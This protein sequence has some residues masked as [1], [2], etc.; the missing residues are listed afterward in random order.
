MTTK[1]VIFAVAT[2]LLYGCG[3]SQPPSAGHAECEKQFKRF[4][5]GTVVE[6]PKVP[7][8]GDSREYYFAWN[9]GS[10]SKPII[11]N[12]GATTGSCV[13]DKNTGK[14]FVTLDNKDLGEFTANAPL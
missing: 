11:T 13:I 12:T 8:W 10:K 1:S 14:G 6:V 4:S 2:S 7:D 5:H 3:S 9:S